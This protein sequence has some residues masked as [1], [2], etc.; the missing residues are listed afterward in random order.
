VRSS[1]STS[2]RNG[3][4][5]AADSGGPR[6][7]E[8]HDFQPLERFEQT[9]ADYLQCVESEHAHIVLPGFET[10]LRVT[11]LL[12][13]LYV[14]VEL[15]RAA[16]VDEAAQDAL[17]WRKGPRDAESPAASARAHGELTLPSALHEVARDR[18]RKGLVVL[19]HPG[20][21]GYP[22]GFSTERRPALRP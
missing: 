22:A 15:A 16:Q 12:E 9:L 5:A 2:V 21:V 13:D 19:G 8:P 17:A 1:G 4:K 14:P 18:R 20:S 7:S 3:A 11:L 6:P 10:R